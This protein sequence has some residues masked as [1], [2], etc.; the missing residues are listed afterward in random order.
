MAPTGATRRP[1]LGLVPT[2]TSSCRPHLVGRRSRGRDAITGG[3][4]STIGTGHRRRRTSVA[5]RPSPD[6]WCTDSD[7]AEFGDQ[8]REPVT[9]VICR[10]PAR[11]KP[12]R[13]NP[14]SAL[15]SSLERAKQA[16]T[17]REGLRPHA[18][19]GLE[20]E[21]HDGIVPAFDADEIQVCSPAIRIYPPSSPT[22]SRTTA[23]PPHEDDRVGTTRAA[24]ILSTGLQ[25][26]RSGKHKIPAGS[27]ALPRHEPVNQ[28]VESDS[29][30]AQTGAC[31]QGRPDDRF[32]VRRSRARYRVVTASVARPRL[33]DD[34]HCPAMHK[35]GRWC[36]R[37]PPRYCFST[38]STDPS[39]PGAI[40]QTRPSA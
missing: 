13:L 7:P 15:R 19:E 20:T 38:A 1:G 33:P 2:A 29:A 23:V 8:S 32:H 11:T 18:N 10:G 36:R 31:S 37:Q 6:A 30:F 26:G 14:R 16:H 5:G 39:V 27:G 3:N 34:C 21:A 40:L 4:R 12:N 28:R 9:R 25:L 22:R 35:R 17:C 24:V